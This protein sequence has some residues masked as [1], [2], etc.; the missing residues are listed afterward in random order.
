MREPLFSFICY[1]GADW[2][3]WAL[4]QGEVKLRVQL[5]IRWVKVN[6]EDIKQALERGLLTEGDWE[7]VRNT[8]IE[9]IVEPLHELAYEE[10]VEWKKNDFN[11]AI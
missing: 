8:K 11:R 3:V 4:L 6:N 5:D 9:D 1:S 10:Q 2:H 7:K